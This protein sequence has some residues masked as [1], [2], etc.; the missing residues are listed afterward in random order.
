[1]SEINPNRHQNDT[2]ARMLAL[3]ALCL[4]DSLGDAFSAD[5]ERF[6][7][8]PH[9]LVELDLEAPLE[10]EIVRAAAKLARQT[11]DHHQDY[12]EKLARKTAH[13]SLKR[14]TPVDRNILRLGLYELLER[15]DVPPKVALNEAIEL[16][17]RFSHTDSP[18]F[19]NGVLDAVRK[20][21]LGGD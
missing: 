17:K 3:Q 8:D 12:D 5:L 19:V 4:F 14:M 16:A 13:W 10:P 2:W 21:V 15:T 7:T 1:M 20:E 6:L 18:A 11:W 9:T